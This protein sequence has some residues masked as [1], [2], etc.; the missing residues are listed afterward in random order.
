[1]DTVGLSESPAFTAGRCS[2]S[3]TRPGGH[4]VKHVVV[5]RPG[6]LLARLSQDPTVVDLRASTSTCRRH[7]ARTLQV[8]VRG[9]A[10]ASVAAAGPASRARVDGARPLREPGSLP[11][12]G[13]SPW[14]SSATCWS[15]PVS[16]GRPALAPPACP[17]LVRCRQDTA[18]RSGS[19][20]SSTST[21]AWSSGS[22]GGRSGSTSTGCASEAGTNV[23]TGQVV[24]VITACFAAPL[25]LLAT[26][27]GIL[28]TLLGMRCRRLDPRGR[29][30]VPRQ[31]P[32]AQVRLAAPR[33]ARRVGK[34]SARGPLVRPG[35]GHDGRRGQ[36]AGPRGV[37]AGSEP[38]PAR[39]PHRAGAGRHVEA[40]GLRELRAGRP[41][42]R[43]PA[44]DRRQRRRVLRPGRRHRAQAP[45]VLDA[46]A[47]P[48]RHR[49]AVRARCCSACRLRWP[50]S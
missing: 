33:A 48:D 30:A 16:A 44:P 38:G 2:R 12:S 45:A 19:T 49:R 23:H 9:A 24:L 1:M 35:A 28:V 10:P 22:A 39:R 26:G 18:P 50:G 14:A 37:P 17:V 11:C 5:P 32:P 8:S 27:V 13:C 7:R 20:R 47:C 29:A 46:G 31:P 41:H 36:R 25:L 34:R 43:R 15:P 4:F 42:H 6:A 3:P 40:A 21:R